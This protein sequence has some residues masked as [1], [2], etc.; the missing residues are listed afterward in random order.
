MAALNRHQVA[1]PACH[2][3]VGICR[4]S[5]FIQLLVLGMRAIFL[6]KD[7]HFCVTLGDSGLCWTLLSPLAFS[8]TAPA[9]AGLLP[10]T[11][12]WKWRSGSSLGSH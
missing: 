2:L 8:N 12:G 3:G 7:G 9:G 11:S 6:L 1:P 10:F 4:Q 5:V